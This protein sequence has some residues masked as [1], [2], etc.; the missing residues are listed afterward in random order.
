MILIL[1]LIKNFLKSLNFRKKRKSKSAKNPKKKRIQRKRRNRRKEKS[2]KRT[3]NN[4]SKSESNSKCTRKLR[5]INNSGNT[6]SSSDVDN[7]CASSIATTTSSPAFKTISHSTANSRFGKI[8][9]TVPPA[10]EF[11]CRQPPHAPLCRRLIH[12]CPGAMRVTMACSS[13]IART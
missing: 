9:A 12:T 11:C 4:K 2:R 1:G 8:F 7:K 6:Y 5:R 3:S 13:I 10:Q